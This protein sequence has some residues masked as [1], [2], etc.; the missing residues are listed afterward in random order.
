MQVMDERFHRQ[1]AKGSRK[2]TPLVV[3]KEPT[4]TNGIQ[5]HKPEDRSSTE[6]RHKVTITKR[7][8]DRHGRQAKQ[9]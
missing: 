2:T 4:T 7:N 5:N 1:Q 9:P 8:D 3:E 6:S